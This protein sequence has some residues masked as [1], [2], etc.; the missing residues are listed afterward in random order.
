[1]QF[2][3]VA[4]G[5]ATTNS[6]ILKHLLDRWPD[7]DIDNAPSRL[8]DVRYSVAIIEKSKQFLGITKTTTISEGLILTLKSWD[9]LDE[10]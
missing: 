5:V 1:M 7:L 3:N 8:G 9:L 10:I 4:T 2:F 6:S